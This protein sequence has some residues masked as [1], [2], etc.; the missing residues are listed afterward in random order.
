MSEERFILEEA[1]V[2][3]GL[4]HPHLPCNVERVESRLGREQ[5]LV[6][7]T[8]TKYLF[9]F[10]TEIMHLVNLTRHGHIRRHIQIGMSKIYGRLQLG[11]IYSMVMKYDYNYFDPTACCR[12]S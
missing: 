5:D 11:A 7:S 3:P 8:T 1:E 6:R 10:T 9:A 2:I 4:R 12:A